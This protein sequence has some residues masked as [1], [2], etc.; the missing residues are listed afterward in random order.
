MLE[1]REIHEHTTL[2]ERRRFQAYFG[3]GLQ[4]GSADLGGPGPHAAGV[5]I[6]N[7]L[8]AP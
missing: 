5:K 3:A 6:S 8:I 4:P 2:L 7:L 1:G